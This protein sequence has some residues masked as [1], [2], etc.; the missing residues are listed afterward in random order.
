M[1]PNSRLVT[2]PV[3]HHAVLGEYPSPCVEQAAIGYLI[4][5]ILRDVS[6]PATADGVAAKRTASSPPRLGLPWPSA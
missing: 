6:C 2:V 1:M 3:S 5:G 4:E